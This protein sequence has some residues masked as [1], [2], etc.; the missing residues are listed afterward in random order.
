MIKTISS[1][2]S[3]QV[4]PAH[5]CPQRLAELFSQ[6]FYQKGVRLRTE[7]GK[8]IYQDLSVKV[9]ENCKVSMSHFEVMHEDEFKNI[10]KA[11]SSSSCQLDPILTTL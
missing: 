6:F 5:E 1:P 11:T 7:L 8:S 2:A 4:L 9:T 10:I 3:R